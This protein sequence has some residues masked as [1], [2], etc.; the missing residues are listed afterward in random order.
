MSIL[1]GQK[2][3]TYFRFGH[4]IADLMRRECGAEIEVKESQGSLAN[5][6]RLRHEVHSQLAIV[7]QDSLDYLKTAAGTDTKL[8]EIARSI[9]YVFPLYAEEV[10]LVTTKGSGNRKLRDLAGKKIAVGEGASGTYLTASFILLLS[11][12]DVTQVE[13][14]PAEGLR[15]LLLPAKDPNRVDALF[16][17]AGTPV[18]LF[19][20]NPALRDQLAAV[21]ID[22]PAILD[23]YSPTKLTPDD[24]EWIT[25]DV[26]TVAVR[27]VLMTYDFQQEQCQNV[28]MVAN[29]LKANLKALKEQFGHAKWAEVDINAPLRGWQAY[30]CVTKYIDAPVE[31]DN[32]QCAFAQT[33]SADYMPPGQKTS[34]PKMAPNPSVCAGGKSDNPIVQSL[35]KNLKELKK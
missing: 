15:R 8:Q 5:L 35:C 21:A 6:Q 3:G 20:E 29:R 34:G 12:I 2:T 32:R 14:G 13:I 24:Y 22:D 33:G 26:N 10:H 19:T 23:R 18:K 9:R 7:Q 31:K 28:G 16:Y 17:V 27:S 4:D 1:T 30:K 25:D 11:G